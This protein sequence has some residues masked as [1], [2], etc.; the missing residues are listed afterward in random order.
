MLPERIRRFRDER[1]ARVVANEGP[2]VLADGPKLVLHLLPI[3]AFNGI[4]SV[5]IELAAKESSGLRPLLASSCDFRYN[6][7]GVLTFRTVQ[8]SGTCQSYVQ[9]FRTGSLEAVSS[10]FV[11]DQRAA[12]L[13]PAWVIESDLIARTRDFLSVFKRLQI[14]TPVVLM[15]SLLGVRGHYIPGATFGDHPASFD[16][17][18]L[19]LPDVLVEDIENPTEAILRP[20]FD[21]MWQASGWRK[22]FNYD[23]TGQRVNSGRFLVAPN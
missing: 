11:A 7:D 12:K 13:F 14:A 20:V 18:D 23:E 2:A 15:L 21:A 1:L 17:D 5:D 22:C 8:N 4:G 16:R 3:S 9:L 6:I 10:Q 19:F